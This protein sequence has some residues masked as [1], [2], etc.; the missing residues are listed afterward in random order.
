MWLRPSFKG[1]PGDLG[2]CWVEGKGSLRGEFNREG[3]PMSLEAAEQ[4]G[5]GNA[6]ITILGEAPGRHCHK[7]PA[8]APWSFSWNLC[9]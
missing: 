2:H 6:A 9:R 5:E 8:A 4:A 3:K 7:S 1:A